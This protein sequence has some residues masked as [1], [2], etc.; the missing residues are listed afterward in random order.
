MYQ[1]S[2]LQLKITK[3]NKKLNTLIETRHQPH[4]NEY[5]IGKMFTDDVYYWCLLMLFH[6]SPPNLNGFS[7]VITAK[8]I[9]LF[10]IKSPWGI[11]AGRK[12][13]KEVS[14]SR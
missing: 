12:D 1:R 11:I 14:A 8:L 5:D 10:Y 7:Q 9:P 3:N 13:L 6:Q 2:M 4:L